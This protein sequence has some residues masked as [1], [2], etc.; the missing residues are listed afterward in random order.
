MPCTKGFFQLLDFLHPTF[1]VNRSLR[2]LKKAVFNLLCSHV[3][4][5]QLAK[6]SKSNYQSFYGLKEQLDKGVVGNLQF[7]STMLSL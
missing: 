3:H 4:D 7:H 5:V 2:S 6:I 1:I